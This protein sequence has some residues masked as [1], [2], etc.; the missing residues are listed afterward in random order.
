MK[1]G[2]KTAVYE[3]IGVIDGKFNYR[4][5]CSDYAVTGKVTI[6]LFLGV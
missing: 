3:E 1:K 6:N 5:K 2:W 4:C